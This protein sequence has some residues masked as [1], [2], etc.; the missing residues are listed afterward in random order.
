M[1]IAKPLAISWILLSLAAA[2]YVG[3]ALLDTY[4]SSKY[5]SEETD[6]GLWQLS[7]IVQHKL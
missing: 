4:I 7:S 6:H 3:D 5:G 2:I 1:R